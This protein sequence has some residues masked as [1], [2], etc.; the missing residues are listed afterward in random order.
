MSVK[1]DF[2]RDVPRLFRQ[3]LFYRRQKTPFKTE[4][5]KFDKCHRPKVQGRTVH[6]DEW[7]NVTPWIVDLI[8]RRPHIVW[9]NQNHPICTT[10]RKIID[11][12]EEQSSSLFFVHED[13][14]PIISSHDQYSPSSRNQSNVYR[15]DKKHM[16]RAHTSNARLVDMVKAGCD[17]LI[18]VGDVHA[19]GP[20]DSRSCHPVFHQLH[21]VQLFEEKRVFERVLGPRKGLNVFEKGER[22]S[23]KQ[24]QHTFDATKVLGLRLKYYLLALTEKLLDKRGTLICKQFHFALKHV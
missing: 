20:I 1:W 23:E 14:C 13:K 17:N 15:L 8:Q 2:W 6:V 21:G 5:M 18:V 24:E 4:I 7:T 3:N 11:I 12:L 9:G 19:R 22:T 16:L 10:K